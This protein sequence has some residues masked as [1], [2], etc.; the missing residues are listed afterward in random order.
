M[1]PNEVDRFILYMLLAIGTFTV[2]R[3]AFKVLDRIADRAFGV[4]EYKYLTQDR[5]VIQPDEFEDKSG[6]I[7]LGVSSELAA[8]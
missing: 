4:V 5:K 1:K 6:D 3:W 7:K 8:R 2:Y